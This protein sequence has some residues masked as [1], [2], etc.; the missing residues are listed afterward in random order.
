MEA[1]N[2]K[3]TRLGDFIEEY[4]PLCVICVNVDK[5]EENEVKFEPHISEMQQ[6]YLDCMCWEAQPFGY[7]KLYVDCWL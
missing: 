7:G 5:P 3:Y 6:K 2:M 4:K 1:N